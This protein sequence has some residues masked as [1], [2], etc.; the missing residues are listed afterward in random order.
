[1]DTIAVLPG[2]TPESYRRHPLHGDAAAWPEKNCYADLWIGF[3][4]TLGLEPLGML[5]FTVAVDFEGDQWTFFKPPL[6]DLR[7]LYGVDVQELTV[8]RPLVGHA[9]EHLAA[10]KLI[11][12]E[13]DAYWL[14]DT[15][16]T[17]YRRSHT[18][19][20]I[21]LAELDT[22]RERL[23]Y[24]H[25]A[26]FFELEGEDFRQLFRIGVPQDPA[27]M[28]FYAELV[29]I[30]RLV[31]RTPSELSDVAFEGLRRHFAWRP[32]TN[33]FSRFAARMA[34]E[35]PQLQAQGLAHYHQWAF[36]SVRQ[37]G[38]AF[39]LLAAH[40]RWLAT[41]GYPELGEPA[42]RFEAIGQANKTLI[43][44]GARAVNSGRPLAADELLQG[45]A[46]DW[47][48]GMAQLVPLLA[49]G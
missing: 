42:A 44:K 16:G 32:R 24:F 38:A 49:A 5:A 9:R 28:P 34:H 19:T 41:Q 12:T 36:A 23:R 1:M 39:E 48:R 2:L 11:S 31:R 33:P 46:A 45:M 3:L 27:F 8:W 43:L 7:S 13:A 15:A 37:A 22:R 35:L 47:E 20:T 40:L 17:D 18:K 4:H 6:E 26:G 25:N 30:D 14:P 10:G 21:L 29:H